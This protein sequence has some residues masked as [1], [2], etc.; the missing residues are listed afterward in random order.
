MPFGEPAFHERTEQPT[1][2]RREDARRK[3]QVARSQDLTAALLLLGSL[4]IH[5]LA[6]GQFMA[7]ALDAVRRGLSQASPVELTSDGA[8]ALFW[9]T[10]A[11]VVRL[12]WPF[13]VIPAA[14]AVAAQL[15]QTRF[16]LSWEALTPQ[17]S[18][19]SPLRGIERL[20]SWEGLVQFLKSML[21]LGAVAGV[22]FLTLRADWPLL[23]AA[24]PAGSHAVLTTVS[25][26]VLDLWLGVGLAYLGLAGLDYGYRWWEHERSLRMTKDEVREE[27]KQ[28]EGNPLLR[29][30]IRS[31][32]RQ[33]A[34]RRMMAEVR[35][36]DVVVR[37]PVHVAVA[38]RYESARMK[39]P[40][41]VG[42]GARLVAQRIVEI[43]RKHGIPVLENPPLARAL[44]RVVAVG[45]EVPRDLYRA[46]AEVLAYVYSLRGGRA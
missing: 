31:L 3:G 10:T 8:L 7:D 17:W 29:G 13:V 18:R 40:R 11:A 30:R 19:L 21:K 14:V 16:A 46:V 25:R 42:K 33:R 15:L 37:N 43:A 22:V 39:A 32:H 1:S 26:V 23:V 2:K 45:Q 6:G 24:G 38:L 36:A 35:R 28:T 9:G 20:L 34:M 41:V 5:S 12:V 4:G 44:F 27:T